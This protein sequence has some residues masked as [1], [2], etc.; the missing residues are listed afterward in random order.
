MAKPSVGF[1]PIAII[2]RGLVLPGA[3]DVGSYAAWLAQSRMR[4]AGTPSD[5]ANASG[6]SALV[7]SIDGFQYDW[8]KHK[9]P[10]K[11]IAQANPLQFMLLEAAE[12]AATLL[13]RETDAGIAY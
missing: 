3:L 9:V 8:R 5:S 13:G 10:P 1:E 4:S 12:Q 7:A 6:V 2:G 11:Q